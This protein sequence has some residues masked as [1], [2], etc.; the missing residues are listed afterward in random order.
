MLRLL[1]DSL[2]YDFIRLCIRAH[3]INIPMIR[4][5]Q[6]LSKAG[7][8]VITR[9]QDYTLIAISQSGLNGR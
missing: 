3:C 9:I 7:K 6:V 8:S 4:N 5:F 2:M 1:L